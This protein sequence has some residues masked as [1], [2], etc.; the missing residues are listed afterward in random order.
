MDFDNDLGGSVWGDGTEDNP[1][2]ELSRTFA[3]IGEVSDENNQEQTGDTNKHGDEALFSRQWDSSEAQEN[4][5]NDHKNDLPLDITPLSFHES[6]NAPRTDTSEL[7]G[8]LA[9]EQDP[10][11][12]L[13]Q[14]HLLVSPQKNDP[15]FGGLDNSPLRIDDDVQRNETTASGPHSPTVSR[16]G[17]LNKLFSSARVRRNPSKTQ[18]K[19]KE[20]SIHDPLVESLAEK[21][22]NEQFVEES[23]NDDETRDVKL[24]LEQQLESPLFMIPD[25]KSASLLESNNRGRSDNA[26]SNNAS[27]VATRN[28]PEEKFEI[29]VINPVKVGELTSAYVEYT[30]VSKGT[31]LENA[32]YRVQRRYRDFRWLYRQLQH[33]NWGH[34]IPPPPEKQAVGRFKQDFIENRRAQME[35]MLQHIANSPVL[36]KDSDFILFLTSEQWSQES[37]LR[38]QISGSKA[39]HDSNDI[40][41][42]HISEIKLLGPEDAERVL[43]SGGLDTDTGSGFM[44]LSFAS[45]PKYKEPDQ[46]FIETAQKTDILEEQLKQL[47]KALE[48]VDSQ[49]SDLCSVI[50]EF[51]DTLNIL[52][53][54]ELS[55]KT[56]E[57]LRNFAEVHLRIKE[58]TSRSSMQD[59]LTLGVTI[60]DHLRTIGSVKA[61]LNQRSKIGY[62]LILVENELNKKKAQLNK[63]SDRSAN[64]EKAKIIENELGICNARYNKIKKEW[65]SIGEVIRKEINQNNLETVEDFRNNMEI[66]LESAI[67]SQKECIEIWETFYQNNL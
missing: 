13:T 7:L 50:N 2:N 67:E 25:R 51:S 1:F 41:D 33:N 39:S 17:K 58:S 62:Y 29:A 20:T 54:L 9:P 45:A 46:F 48:L 18:E 22:K 61:I 34:I 4:V 11:H 10:L 38:E 16:T 42:I 64:V 40:S 26:N 32:E 24:S 66:Y 60:D 6:S 35:R 55:K 59:S 19:S 43:K 8:S 23:L 65:Q 49:R 28:E 27:S 37:K 3:K 63:I 36:Q 52:A 53:D 15:L 47:Y 44:G 12:E 31:P 30:V 57:L 21:E 14:T 5:S 56:S